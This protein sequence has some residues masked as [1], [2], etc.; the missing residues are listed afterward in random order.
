MVPSAFKIKYL[1]VNKHYTD[2][3]LRI[4]QKNLMKSNLFRNLC[5]NFRVK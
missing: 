3:G 2:F 4:D 5:C 1:H